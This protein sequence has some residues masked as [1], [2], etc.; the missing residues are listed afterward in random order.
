MGWEKSFPSLHPRDCARSHKSHHSTLALVA[1][2]QHASPCSPPHPVACGRG[3]IGLIWSCRR[4][5]L[6]FKSR[7]MS[8]LRKRGHV[9]SFGG[10]RP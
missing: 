5:T 7:D 10:Q 9:D 1:H 3:T 4:L 2:L 6:Y 8:V